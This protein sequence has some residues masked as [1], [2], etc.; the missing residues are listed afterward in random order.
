M[1]VSKFLAGQLTVKNFEESH[2]I[3]SRIE[4]LKRHN[5]TLDEIKYIVDYENNPKQF[6]ITNKK[7]EITVLNNRLKRIYEKIEQN[8]KTNLSTDKG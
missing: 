3:L 6:F 7:I 4:Y 5:L 1:P 8:Q 2:K